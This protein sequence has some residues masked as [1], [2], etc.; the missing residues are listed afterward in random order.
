MKAIAPM[1]GNDNRAAGD[2]AWMFLLE[3]GYHYATNRPGPKDFVDAV[4]LGAR[5][6][7]EKS[8]RYSEVD[9]SKVKEA[10]ERSATERGMLSSSSAKIGEWVEGTDG[11]TRLMIHFANKF[12]FIPKSN[13]RGNFSGRQF[14]QQYAVVDDALLKMLGSG[15]I[16]A[17]PAGDPDR[18]NAHSKGDVRTDVR[19]NPEISI[20][21]AKAL[22]AV[23]AEAQ[24]LAQEKREEAESREQNGA[25]DPHES[26]SREA[27]RL[28][29]ERA[30]ANALAGLADPTTLK[31]EM[32]MMPEGYQGSPPENIHY[33]FALPGAEFYVD[34]RTGKA[35]AKEMPDW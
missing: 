23:I 18:V 14:L 5:T 20:E 8:E 29:Y 24:R 17:R 30:L 19:I 13:S 16:L 2:L 10:L 27:S 25:I 11:M 12:A 22:Q 9:F 32:V 33:R 15:L 31:V 1:V 4:T 26:W 6:Y 3:H 21:P 34:A 35:A 28:R 7:L